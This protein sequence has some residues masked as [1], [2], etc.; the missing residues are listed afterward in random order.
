MRKICC[1]CVALLCAVVPTVALAAPG[2]VKG[3]PAFAGQG[4]KG[5]GKQ[6][7]AL[8]KNGV[9][10]PQLVAQVHRLQ[11]AKGI[12]QVNGKGKPAK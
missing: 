7:S 4:S 9:H 6:V 11:A 12:G 3:P 5:I 1:L 8:A 2:G 10:G